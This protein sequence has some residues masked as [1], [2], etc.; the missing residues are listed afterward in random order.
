MVRWKEFSFVFV[1]F[2]FYFEMFEWRGYEGIED[3]KKLV[4]Y[5]LRNVG[6]LKIVMIYLLI[7]N[8]DIRRCKIFKNYM[9]NELVKFFGW[10][11]ICK[12]VFR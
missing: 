3:E 5:I 11:C 7:L 6:R 2:V 1:C 8:S 10:L 4:S 9:S 12:F